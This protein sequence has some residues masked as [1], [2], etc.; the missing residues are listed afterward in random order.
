MISL[1][2]VVGTNTIL[3]PMLGK[4]EEVPPLG[5]HRH[6]LGNCME[7]ISLAYS[8]RLR[9]MSGN[10]RQAISRGIT[11]PSREMNIHLYFPLLQ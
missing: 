9:N 11:M 7:D 1:A 4:Q 10:I 2:L 3:T 8:L 5:G 6:P